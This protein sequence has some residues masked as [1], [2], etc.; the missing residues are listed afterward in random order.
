MNALYNVLIADPIHVG[1][2]ELLTSDARLHVD[3]ETGLDEAALTERI[4]TYDA[5]IVRS[6]TVSRD[7]SSPPQ[8]G[9]GS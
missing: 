1:G 9:L 4:P 3:M 5:L 6:N 8:Y 2:R 7:R